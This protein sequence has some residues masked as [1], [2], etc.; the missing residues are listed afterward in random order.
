MAKLIYIR[1]VRI[2]ASPHQ[3]AL[4]A[5]VGVWLGVFPTFGL[6][7]FL[8]YLLAGPFRFNKA[9]AFAGAA[10]TNPLTSPVVWMISALVGGWLAGTDWHA[11]YELAKHERYL[12][13][14][15]RLTV[16]YLVGNVPLAT[17]AAAISYAVVYA[18]AKRRQE[19]K[20][21]RRAAGGNYKRE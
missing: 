21:R 16:V 5:A 13:A 15:G 8:A 4:G 17:V 12:L 2:N 10:V 14:F 18:G 6:A 19:A 20:R 3:L 11:V 1:V 9:A 7:G